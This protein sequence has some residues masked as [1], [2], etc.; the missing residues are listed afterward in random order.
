M[1]ISNH[2]ISPMSINDKFWNQLARIKCLHTA[3]AWIRHYSQVNKIFANFSSSLTKKSHLLKRSLPPSC[4]PA[5][6]ICSRGAPGTQAWLGVN[7][8]WTGWSSWSV[9]AA[10]SACRSEQTQQDC[11]PLM[12][13]DRREPT[14]VQSTAVFINC[15]VES[16]QVETSLVSMNLKYQSNSTVCIWCVTGNAVQ[17]NHGKWQDSMLLGS[18]TFHSSSADHVTRHRR[19]IRVGHSYWW[20]QYSLTCS[21]NSHIS[22]RFIYPLVV[23]HTH[24]I[25][26][27]NNQIWHLWL[28]D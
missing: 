7:A 12:L 15:G 3:S 9:W 22:T 25:A 6:C 4:P 2:I 18:P 10:A 1:G 19:W 21:G 11:T 16:F 17:L 13:Q 27:L 8:C 28:I 5:W 24:Y 14:D 20:A 26:F 23:Y